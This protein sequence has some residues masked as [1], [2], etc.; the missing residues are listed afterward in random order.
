LSTNDR[1]DFESRTFLRTDFQNQGESSN[2]DADPTVSWT[3][4]AEDRNDEH[5]PIILFA[6]GEGTDDIVMY[7]FDENEANNALD[8]DEEL[9]VKALFVTE[10]DAV[11]TVDVDT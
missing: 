9:T 10:S 2:A 11:C 8:G 6:E 1:G 7:L 4:Y 5:T 3:G